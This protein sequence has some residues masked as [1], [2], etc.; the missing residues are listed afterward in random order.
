MP[1]QCAR[2]HSYRH[3]IGRPWERRLL[4]ECY[5]DMSAADFSR[6]VLERADA[7]GIVR[8]APCGWSDWGTPERVLASL[9]GTPEHA[10]LSRRLREEDARRESGVA[11]KAAS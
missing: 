4:S 6:D 7:L 3:A 8:L 1:A 10:R 5:D 9:E 2:L 11:L